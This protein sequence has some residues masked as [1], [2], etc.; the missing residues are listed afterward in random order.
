MERTN[1]L[2]SPVAEYTIV[3]PL[4]LLTHL[5][6]NGVSGLQVP[7]LLRNF[8]VRMSSDEN[9]R[10]ILDIFALKCAALN[11]M[12]KPITV[13]ALFP[14]YAPHLDWRM[15]AMLF[16]DFKPIDVKKQVTKETWSKCLSKFTGTGGFVVNARNAPFCDMII[17]PKEGKNVILI[18]EK[19]VEVAKSAAINDKKRKVTSFDCSKVNFE[20]EKCMVPTAHLFV[21]ISDG[22][23]NGKVERLQNNEIVLTRQ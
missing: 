23:F 9:E 14:G 22:D 15:N 3:F 17:I 20:H 21:L 6:Q 18:Q 2:T 13:E 19:Q 16:D 11:A 12:E 5:L 1:A 10:N 8:N 7:M 4:L